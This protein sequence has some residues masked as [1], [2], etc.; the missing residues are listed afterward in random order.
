MLFS[1]HHYLFRV[2]SNQYG[3]DLPLK[4]ISNNLFTYI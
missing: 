2:I 3:K 1:Y 4:Y